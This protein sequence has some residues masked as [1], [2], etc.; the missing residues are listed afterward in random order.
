MF[1]IVRLSSARLPMKGKCQ[2]ALKCSST[3]PGVR[4][5]LLATWFCGAMS[6]SS[7]LSVNP[8]IISQFRDCR[9]SAG[10]VY[11]VAVRALRL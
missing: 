5:S 9:R 6:C 1:F 2:L 10:G 11:G 3:A 8:S 7:G 4:N